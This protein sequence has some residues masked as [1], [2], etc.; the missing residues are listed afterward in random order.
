M[1]KLIVSHP[2]TYRNVNETPLKVINDDNIKFYMLVYSCGADS[3]A[4]NM[5]GDSAQNIVLLDYHPSRTGK[6]AVDFLQ[7]PITTLVIYK[8]IVGRLPLITYHH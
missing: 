3:L 2:K 6:Y 7:V 8:R 1:N 5:Q 4:G